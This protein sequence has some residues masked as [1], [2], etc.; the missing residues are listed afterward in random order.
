M[1]WMTQKTTANGDASTSFEVNCEN[2]S[3]KSFSEHDTDG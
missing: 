1:H 3:D 2:G